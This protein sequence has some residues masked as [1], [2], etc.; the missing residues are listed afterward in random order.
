MSLTVSVGGP[1][2]ARNACLFSCE[3]LASAVVTNQRECG[4]ETSGSVQEGLPCCRHF[5]AAHQPHCRWCNCDLLQTALRT[6]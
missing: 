2:A 4:R 3:V 1:V 6:M 5:L